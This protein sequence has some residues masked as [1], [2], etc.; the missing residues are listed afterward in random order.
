MFRKKDSTLVKAAQAQGMVIIEARYLGQCLVPEIRGGAVVDAGIQ[1][2]SPYFV[3][4]S[5]G[6]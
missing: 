2:A 3:R 1:K 6:W 5:C 4:S